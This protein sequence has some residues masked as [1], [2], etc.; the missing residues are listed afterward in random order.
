MSGS[1]I[2]LS[3]ASLIEVSPGVARLQFTVELLTPAA[4]TFS[5]SYRTLRGCLETRSI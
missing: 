1:L 5:V 2:R 3:P 4:N